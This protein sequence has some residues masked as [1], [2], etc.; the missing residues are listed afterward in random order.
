MGYKY[1]VGTDLLVLA[2]K[3][4]EIK[5]VILSMFSKMYSEIH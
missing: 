1:S 2:D 4:S 3:N 5:S